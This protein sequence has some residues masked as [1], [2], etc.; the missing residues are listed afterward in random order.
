MPVAETAHEG[1]QIE[2][3]TMAAVGELCRLY[4]VRRLDIFG[5]A[6][7]ADFDPARSD[8]DLLVTFDDA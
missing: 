6:V 7:R 2:A 8:V 1:L 3:A 5:S 4:H